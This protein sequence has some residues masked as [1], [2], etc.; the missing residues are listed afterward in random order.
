[1]TYTGTIHLKGLGTDLNLIPV[2]YS[3][4]DSKTRPSK[5]SY[6]FSVTTVHKI[7]ASRLFVNNFF[8]WKYLTTFK[9]QK[10]GEKICC[11]KGLA[12]SSSRNRIR[13]DILI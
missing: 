5:K 2:S 12:Q 3:G 6:S 9:D 1:L 10:N 4:T 13:N 8:L 11:P 7:A